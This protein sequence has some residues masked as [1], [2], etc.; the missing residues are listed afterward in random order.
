VEVTGM[1]AIV[2][3]VTTVVA[4]TGPGLVLVPGLVQ[5]LVQDLVHE[6]RGIA[7][8]LAHQSKIV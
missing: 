5:D 2:T 8:G 4:V 1:M 7:L 6:K 3:I